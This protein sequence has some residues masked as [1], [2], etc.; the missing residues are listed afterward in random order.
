VLTLG[1]ALVGVLVWFW[2]ALLYLLLLSPP[3]PR[4]ARG[5]RRRR[6]GYVKPPV[7]P[8]LNP[9]MTRALLVPGTSAYFSSPSV[10]G[11]VSEGW[12]T[13]RLLR[14][15]SRLTGR[16]WSTVGTEALGAS[17][18]QPDCAA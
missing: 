1:I 18:Q 15:P 6:G 8:R 16:G 5:R 11:G 9:G 7:S 2:L 17:G 3:G 12:E 4:R 14:D 10:P 13:P